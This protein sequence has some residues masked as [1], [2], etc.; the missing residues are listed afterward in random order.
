MAVRRPYLGR[1]AASRSLCKSPPDNDAW[2][3]ALPPGPVQDAAREFQGRMGPSAHRPEQVSVEFAARVLLEL[4]AIVN[5][6]NA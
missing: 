5:E 1:S 2:L 4:D 3:A 6:V